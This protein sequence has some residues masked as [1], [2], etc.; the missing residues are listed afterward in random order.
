MTGEELR[1]VRKRLGLTQVGL[2]DQLAVTPT[3]VARWERNE[4]PIRETMA[5]MI[6]LLVETKGRPKGKRR[7][8]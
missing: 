1:R 2:A 8:H 7:K 5:R 3:T 6:R 4:V